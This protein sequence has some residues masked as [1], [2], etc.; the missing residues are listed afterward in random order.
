MFPWSVLSKIG[1]TC[2]LLLVSCLA[3][4]SNS[5]TNTE[6]LVLSGV[7]GN[8]GGT[9]NVSRRSEPRTLNPLIA[10]DGTSKELISLLMADLIHINRLT[11]RT[12]AALAKSWKISPDGRT[13]TVYLRRGVH[14][15]DGEP[16]DADDVVFTLDAYLDEKTH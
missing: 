6:S 10:I 15:S 8:C 4:L 5:S 7:N 11:Q 12:E 13:F 14:F 3:S 9:L 1:K 2:P 16:L